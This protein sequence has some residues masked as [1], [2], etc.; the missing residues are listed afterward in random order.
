M[1]KDCQA[2]DHQQVR[3]NFLGLLQ[4]HPMGMHTCSIRPCKIESVKVTCYAARHKRHAET[5]VLS[6]EIG[7]PL[8]KNATTEITELKQELK[9]AVP[10][11]QVTGKFLLLQKT[12]PVTLRVRGI[13][14]E[15][16][17]VLKDNVCG[18]KD[19]MFSITRFSELDKQGAF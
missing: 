3:K 8:V 1:T 10:Y 18:K 5:L 17:Q 13:K 11:F 19:N 14:C 15:D 16:G 7:I 9:K 4:N 12:T 6:F 2:H